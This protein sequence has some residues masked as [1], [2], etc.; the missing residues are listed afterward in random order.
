MHEQMKRLY[1]AAL[2][3]RSISGQSVLARALNESP[4]TVKNWETR[5]ISKSGIIKSQAVIGCHASWLEDGVG[6][7]QLSNGDSPKIMSTKKL[8]TK[9]DLNYNLYTIDDIR[10]NIPVLS[11]TQVSQY[12]SILNNFQ[13]THEGSLMEMLE[14]SIELK[15]HTFAIRI[16]GDSMEPDFREGSMI[17]VEPDMKP[18]SGDYVVAKT[19]GTEVTFK[20]LIKDNG[21]WYL[22]PVND[23]YP[24]KPLGNAEIIGVVR[25]VVRKLR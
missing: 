8:K 9:N 21:D 16:N 22:K 12:L 13:P 1:E 5:G 25:E 11:N 20:Q 10:N 14:T 23:R 15:K 2:K 7:M 24:I 4:Q 3:L 17:V 19:S 6:E 18:E